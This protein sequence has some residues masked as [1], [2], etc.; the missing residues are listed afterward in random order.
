MDEIKLPDLNYDCICCGKSCQGWKVPLDE[1]ARVRLES[2]PLTAECRARG[3]EPLAA[4][5]LGGTEEQGCYYLKG[6]LCGLHSADGIEIKPRT[7]RQFPY[8]PVRTPDGIFVGVSFRCTAVRLGE[9]RPLGQD[10]ERHQWLKDLSMP[11][12]GFGPIKLNRGS[13]IDWQGYLRLEAAAYEGLERPNGIYDWAAR[14]VEPGWDPMATSR[15]F[16]AFMEGEG[17]EHTQVVEQCLREKRRFRSRRGVE[18]D[19]SVQVRDTEFEELI[20]RYLRQLLHRKFLLGGPH[21]AARA[22]LFAAI[23][24]LLRFNLSQA[25]L[26]LGDE[27]GDQHRE[28]A[29]D[30]VESE[31]V[32]HQAQGRKFLQWFY[33]LVFGGAP[34]GK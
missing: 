29:I 4:D 33:N 16:V 23:P 2:H 9:G 8:H 27:V 1:E 25:T 22:L 18:M 21:L 31:L 15:A 5:N 3:L 28:L 10:P 7:C 14:L 24:S 30:R 6:K 26:I 34:S 12:Y 19:P 11:R 17:L 13:S 32:T 20:G